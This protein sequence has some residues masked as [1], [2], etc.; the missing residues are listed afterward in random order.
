MMQFMV[1]GSWGVIP[2]HINELVPDSVRGF[3]PG[4]AYQLGNLLATGTASIQA[5]LA[6]ERGGDYALVMAVWMAAVALVLAFL[7][8]RG[9][10]VRGVS[11]EPGRS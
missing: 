11:F 9:P 10:E 1:Q 6:A 5:W 7:A 8:W 4:F 2:V 3:L